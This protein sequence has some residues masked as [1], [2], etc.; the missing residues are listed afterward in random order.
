MLLSRAVAVATVEVSWLGAVQV[1]Q[2][3]ALEGLEDFHRKLIPTEFLEG[4]VV[5]L[6]HLL[7]LLVAFIGSNLMSRLVDEIWGC[8]LDRKTAS[9]THYRK[10][11][12][13]MRKLAAD[14]TAEDVQDEILSLADDYDRIAL[15]A[16]GMDPIPLNSRESGNGV[17]K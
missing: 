5:L 14:H 4:R 12:Q 11:A 16:D 6:A 10:R 9:V 17:K 2:D 7:G 8:S 15:S 1:Q 3:G 13:E